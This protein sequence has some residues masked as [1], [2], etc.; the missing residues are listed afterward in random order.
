M[1]VQVQIYIT[2]Q[3]KHVVMYII[4][5]FVCNVSTKKCITSVN[6][7]H[8]PFRN[9]LFLY[10]NRHLQ[11]LFIVV[12]AQLNFFKLSKNL[13]DHDRCIEWCKETYS[14]RH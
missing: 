11:T 3:L 12:I 6:K 7:K 5:A 8:A 13:A 1:Q 9:A 4:H 2:I 10:Y 14:R